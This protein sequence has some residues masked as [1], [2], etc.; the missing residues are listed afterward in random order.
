MKHTVKITL[1][2]IVAFLISQL[3]GLLMF[4]LY[5][6]NFGKSYQDKVQELK[7][8]NISLPSAPNATIMDFVSA[9]VEAKE[10]IDFIKLAINLL[11][12]IALAIVLFFVLTRIGVVPVLK[13]WF[14]LVIFICLSIALTLLLYPLLGHHLLRIGGLRFSFAEVIGIPLAG[15]LTYF[16]IFKRQLLIHNLTEL[17]IYPGFAIVLLPILNVVVATALLLAISIY[18][19]VSVWRSNYMVGLAN[20]QVKHL[21]VF[22]GFFIPYIGKGDRAKINAAKSLKSKKEKMSR[23]QKIKVRVAALGGGDIAIPMVFLG[24]IFLAYG[25]IAYF[26]VLAFILAALAALLFTAKD[27][28]YP[29]MPYLAA[30][31]LIGLFIVLLIFA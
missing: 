19:I 31:A 28:A 1:I 15:V 6:Q 13:G 29:A 30:G 8:K 2:I 7:D 20:F 22:S 23:L 18:D 16:K 25:L 11:I 10:P 4:Q 17:F 9:P 24:T 12:A 3:I 14:S 27:K 21:K 26:I 5:D